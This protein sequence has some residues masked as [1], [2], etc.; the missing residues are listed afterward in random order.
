MGTVTPEGV[1]VTERSWIAYREAWV[2]L[3]A[4]V[5]PDVR[6]DAWRAWLTVDRSAMLRCF[7]GGE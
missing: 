3:G 4:K 6:A 2:A 5:R 7:T 1:R